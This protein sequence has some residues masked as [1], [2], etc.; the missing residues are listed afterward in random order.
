MR[1]SR[2]TRLL[3]W[4]QPAVEPESSSGWLPTL[5]IRFWVLAE[6][7]DDSGH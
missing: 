2:R 3:Y 4:H 5:D 6:A 7:I 1:S